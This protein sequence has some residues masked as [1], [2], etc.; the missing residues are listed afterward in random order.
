VGD[1]ELIGGFDVDALFTRTTN[2]MWHLHATCVERGLTQLADDLLVALSELEIGPWR[3]L[4][5]CAAGA[6]L[7]FT[8]ECRL[9]DV[10]LDKLQESSPGFGPRVAIEQTRTWL[11]PH[12]KT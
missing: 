2:L 6:G 7:P 3:H 10:L 1:D 11:D 9:L 8:A 4:G 5:G 12:H